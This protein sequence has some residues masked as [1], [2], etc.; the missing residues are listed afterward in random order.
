[1]GQAELPRTVA[2]FAFLLAERF[3]ER[4]AQRFKRDQVVPWAR[5]Q[6]LPADI[7]GVQAHPSVRELIQGMVD[8]ANARYARV[9]Q[10]KRFTVLERDFTVETGEL[11]PTLK[12]KRRVVEQNYT[13]VL[14]RLYSPA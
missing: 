7:V 13:G 1:M 14:E 8:Q 4:P 10:I 2:E 5:A 6:G 12:I 11:T 9:E 3:G